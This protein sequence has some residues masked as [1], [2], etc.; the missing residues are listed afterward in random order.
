V[1][2]GQ[3]DQRRHQLRI[4]DEG[5]A[6]GRGRLVA[7]AFVLLVASWSRAAVV[8][9]TDGTFAIT[10]WEIVFATFRSS[11]GALIGGNA[12]FSQVAEGRPSPSGRIELALPPAPTLT[13]T[14]STFSVSFR[15]G[16]T[17]DPMTQGS[18][19]TVDYEEDA[20]VL[21]APVLTGLAVRQNGELYFAQAE[22]V[23][24]DSWT[25]VVRKKILQ[26]NFEHLTPGGVVQGEYPDFSSAG[27]PIEVGVLRANS[28]GQGRPTGYSTPALIDNWLVRVNPVCTEQLDCEDGDACGVE[29]CVSGNCESTPLD[30]VDADDC[31]IDS[32]V[33]GTCIHAANDCSDG[34][35]CTV[36]N[37]TAGGECQH[38]PVAC[39]DADA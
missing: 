31:T 13:E 37:C 28:T 6:V 7:L 26:T 8:T 15:K 30:C 9:V 20:R 2:V 29:A 1:D 39:D 10:D 11:G 34:D 21:V 25:H 18:I 38:A 4:D 16:F 12:Q 24:S 3:V 33:A 36:D 17:Y 14:A 32:C 35:A 23:M 22:I 27:A 19:A 5:L